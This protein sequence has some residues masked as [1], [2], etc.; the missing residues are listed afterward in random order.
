MTIHNDILGVIGNTPVVR[1]QHLAP[2]GVELFVKLEARNP[3]GSVKDRLALGIIEA[4]EKSGE[5]KPGQTVVEATSGNTGLG[6]AMVC[7][8]KGYPLVIVM[9]ENF[10]LERRKMLRFL[11]AKVVLSPP[12]AKGTGMIAIAKKL[13]EDNGWFLA[14]QFE[15]EA[16]PDIHSRTTA[17]EIIRDFGRNGLNAWVTGFGSGGTLKGVARVL[18]E[19][20]PA[21][22][23]IVVEPENAALVGSGIAQDAAAN[24]EPTKSHPAFH[25]HPIQGVT[26]DFISKLTRDA[27]AE[28]MVDATIGVSGAEAIDTAVQLARREGIFCGISSGATV[29]AAIKA[30]GDMPPGSRILAMLADTGER[31]LTTPLFG[32]ISVEMDEAEKA[33][34]DAAMPAIAV[35]PAPAPAEAPAAPITDETAR[36]FVADA[37]ANNHGKVVMFAMSWCEFCWTVRKLLTALGVPFVSI[38]IDTSEFRAANDVPKIRAALNE[39]AGAPTIPQVYAGGTHL[40]GCMDVLAAAETGELQRILNDAGIPMNDRILDPYEFLP[41]WVKLPKPVAA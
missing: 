36:K 30:A 33:L 14:R 15:N 38:D 39:I 3:L 12:W 40:G 4:A 11:G 17:V 41:N 7:A 34:L 37:I 6:L 31:Y 29:A 27:V 32:D 25:P 26:P 8:A 1:L 16:G 13:A 24:G 10:S 35:Q 18:R 19:Q 21:T 22:R 2:E 23:I 20:S 9:A 28:K 5:L